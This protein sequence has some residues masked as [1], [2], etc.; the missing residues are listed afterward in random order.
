METVIEK[1][2]QNNFDGFWTMFDKRWAE[3]GGTVFYIH[4][5]Q[6]FFSKQFADELTEKT[7]RSRLHRQLEDWGRFAQQVPLF[8]E[9]HP[10]HDPKDPTSLKPV[11]ML[12]EEAKKYYWFIIGAYYNLCCLSTYKQT[13]EELVLAVNQYLRRDMPTM[14]D[15]TK[16]RAYEAFRK[17]LSVSNS[18]L[19]AEWTQELIHKAVSNRD[20][21]FFVLMSKA[22]TC[23]M[24]SEHYYVARQW[25][26]TALLWYLGGKDIKPRRRFLRFLKDKSIIPEQKEEEP[27]NADL[28][29]LGLTKDLNITK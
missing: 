4:P 11:L 12:T 21:D 18:F 7:V 3:F 20:Q 5:F 25:L 2:A 14:P 6:G 15:S 17:L 9:N 24:P 19:L 23:D 8:H 10:F 27:F 22:L 13:I 26:G 1:V 16:E 29:K 28:S